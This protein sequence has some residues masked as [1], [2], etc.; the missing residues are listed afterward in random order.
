MIDGFLLKKLISVFLNV[1]PG[2]P[3]LLLISLLLK[4]WWPRACYVA[5][6]LLCTLLILVSVPAVSN[7]L[8]A[9][10]ENQFPV[11]QGAPD[12]TGL[13]LVHGY[14]HV[15]SDQLPINTQL[16][17]VALARL[18]EA[19]RLWQSK[20]DTTLALSGAPLAKDTPS[21]ATKMYQMALVLGVPAEKMIRFDQA[22][23]T[24]DEIDSAVTWLNINRPD[25]RLVSVSTAM[26]LPRINM[27]LRKHKVRRSL[28]PT[29]FIVSN[30]ALSLPSASALL[31]VDR[32]VHEYVGMLWL[33]V[34]QSLSAVSLLD[35]SAQ[36]DSAVN[37]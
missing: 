2:L 16:D 33:R 29:E 9:S 3:V 15:L 31:S 10:L 19:V 24:E 5:A 20:S 25:S 21:H 32:V 7:R 35:F 14:G 6:I 8:V 37:Q 23:D 13:I 11:L 17:P 34:K 30:R 27:I 12:D 18:S 28:A 26:H 22:L 1:I 36:A 4:R